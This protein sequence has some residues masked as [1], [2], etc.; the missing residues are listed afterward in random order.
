VPLSWLIRFIIFLKKTTKA[1]CNLQLSMHNSNEIGVIGK[2]IIIKLFL[3]VNCS[4]LVVNCSRRFE[5]EPLPLSVR[6]NLALLQTDPQFVMYFNF[7]KM[8]ETEFWKKFI[9]DSLFNSERNFGNFLNVLKNASGVSITDGIDELYF[10]NSWIGDN[11][12]VIK[13]T[14]DRGRINE[15]VKSDTNFIRIPYPNGL[16]IY[17]QVPAHF[18]FYF[19]DDF[20]VC[21]SN[22]LKQIESTFEVKDSSVAG[23]LTNADAVKM[24]E[25]IKYKENLWMFSGQ[26][27]FI[28]G[29][30]ENFGDIGKTGEHKEP[31]SSGTDS[32]MKE[33]S[34]GSEAP[35]LFAIYKK[36][37]AVS[38]CL[39]MT[40][41]LNIVMQNECEDEKSASELKGRLEGVIALA[42]LS[43]TF[44]KKKPNAVLQI[45]DKIKLNVYDKTLLLEV[46]IDENQITA[47]R[48]QKVF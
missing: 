10:S 33:D 11:A 29:I 38:F 27:L 34:T 22:Y 30:F 25:R 24:I 44:S 2:R 7:K 13:G 36:I 43:S 19:K 23:L 37:N 26:K 5:P 8:K 31:E 1:I 14:F 46:R 28:R 3:I 39:K 32:L 20:T 48:K 17:N 21:A 35:D 41:E 45:L 42:K 12:M 6:Q 47:I 16:V 4:L 9:S 40:D 15:Y 18:Y